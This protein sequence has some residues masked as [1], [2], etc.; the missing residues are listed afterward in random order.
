VE[1][2]GQPYIRFYLKDNRRAAVE[3]N[4]CGILTRY[5]YKS[6]LFGE[7]N[8]AMKPVLDLIEMQ[9]Q[10]I[11]EG[12]KNGASYRFMAQSD[13]WATDEDLADEMQ[14]FNKF[15]F[16]NKKTA[17]G[18]VLFPNTYTNVQQLKQEAYKVDA[19]QQKL[20]DSHVFDYFAVNEEILQNKAFGDAWLAFYEGAVEWLAIQ[21]SDV[22]SKMLFSERER[23]FGNRVFFT[24]NRLQYM[25]NADKMT[26]V[27]QL[28][29]RGLATRN[30]LREILNL[31]PL[32]EPYGSQIPARGEY[33]DVKEGDNNA[34]EV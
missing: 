8:E 14:R 33:Y 18:L 3:L 5:Q 28:A 19:D 9:R 31:A 26:A 10:G 6:E 7:S 20:I 12:V 25:S 17:G 22:M 15:T 11:I 30:E 4:E 16:G 34:D 13:N 32:P 27:S 23:Q 21:L 1:Y 2:N 24:S 29:D